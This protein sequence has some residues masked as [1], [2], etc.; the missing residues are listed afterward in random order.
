MTKPSVL[1]NEEQRLKALYRLNILDTSKEERFDRIT[2][3]AKSV[4]S[5]DFASISLIDSDRQWFKSTVNLVVEQT[6]RDVALCAHTIAEKS[7]LIVPDTLTDKRFKDNPFVTEEPGI[8]FYAGVNLII[9]DQAIGTL[10]VFHSSTKSFSDDDLKSLIDLGKM[11][12]TE[13]LRDDSE[14]LLVELHQYQSQFEQAQKLVR[15]R[16]EI[17]E[18]VVSSESLYDILRT[19]VLQIEKEYKGYYC[20]IL[21]LEGDRLRLG[22]APSLPDFYNDAIDGVQI[23]HGVGSCGNSAFHNE[24]TIVE[25][26]STHEFWKPWAE[27]AAKA[28]LGSCWSQPIQGPKNEVLGTFAIYHHKKTTPSK[29]AITLIE[30]FAH[31][32][33]IAI[34]RD[35]SNKVIW[36]QANFDKLTGLPNRSF[37]EGRL[38]QL[39]AS[40]LRQNNKVAVLFLDLDNFKDVNDT[41]GHDVGDL[42]L[43]DCATRI[44]SCLR[45]EDVV[46][47][48]G[49]DEFIILIGNLDSHKSLDGVIENLLNTISAPYTLQRQV[50]HTSVSIG[51]S[52]FPDDAMAVS[53]LVKNADQAMYS[54]KSKGKNNCQFYSEEMQSVALKRLSIKAD[55]RTAIEERQFYLEY[56]PI[57]DLASGKCSKVEALIRWK[58]PDKGIIRPDEFIPIAEESGVIV[59]I[60]NWVFDEVVNDAMRWRKR[61][62]NEIQISINTS[63]S[64]YFSSQPSIMDWLNVLLEK[65]LSANAIVLEIT[66]NLL[67]DANDTVSKKLFQFRQAGVGIALDD[68]GTGFSSISYLKK[69]PTDIIKIDRSF[70]HSMTEVSNDKVLCEAII[71]MAKKLGIKV[72]AEGIETKEQLVILKTMGCD[73]GQGYYLSKPL[74]K[75]NIENYLQSEALKFEKARQ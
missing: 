65:G 2:R 56:Q 7:F 33:S 22:A 55:L 52:L 20:S 8:R 69:F 5:C 32:A 46:S 37:M 64:H 51:V 31:I 54:A 42:L 29:S 40:A 6:P 36:K 72:V 60:S 35:T 41:L 14:A 10:C 59:E 49:G 39:M 43:N 66:E 16:S 13:L 19:I 68:F 74:S 28:N 4:F 11:V 15:V 30:Q 25:D 53:D 45:N 44:T 47:R 3:L 21:L 62:N 18:K 73:Y 12:E 26:I 50:V 71:V 23:G 27:L 67:M 48:F 57:H 38:T 75:E 34:E 17:L 63:P 58:H 1:I 9:D 70:V 24:L 61:F